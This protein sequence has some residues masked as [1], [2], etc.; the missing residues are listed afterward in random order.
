[1]ISLSLSTIRARVGLCTLP[2]E[3]NSWPSLSE[4]SDTNLVSDAPQMR[5]MTCLASAELARDRSILTRFLKDAFISSLVNDE[6]L[7]RQVLSTA[8]S[9][10]A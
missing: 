1:M 4:A 7:T 2:T 10:N 6:N 5:S 8:S 3:R 9:P